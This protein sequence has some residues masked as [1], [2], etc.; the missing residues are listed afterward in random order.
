VGLRVAVVICVASWLG[1]GWAAPRWVHPLAGPERSLPLSRTREFGA[2]RPFRR[3]PECRRGH[4]GVDLGSRRGDSVFAVYDGIVERIERD[5]DRDPRSGRYVRL[6]HEGGTLV[7]RYIH[8]D[9]IRADLREG[10]RVA[11]GEII[12]TLG[13]TGVFSSGP[14]LHFSISARPGGR[15]ARERYLDPEPFL[16]LW[17]LKSPSK[18]PAKTRLPDAVLASVAHPEKVLASLFATPP[19]AA[20][21]VATPAPAPRWVPEHWVWSQRGWLWVPAGWRTPRPAGA[22]PPAYV[23]FWVPGHWS[24]SGRAWIW[25]PGGWRI[26]TPGPVV[27]QDRSG[28]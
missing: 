25:I 16:R 24:W 26:H 28:S 7:T 15:G 6:G 18:A 10:D 3:P 2:S 8:L 13:S 17:S 20:P 21:P 14:H 11:G 1:G 5:A 4:C 19:E 9:S 27:A 23:A 22:P 12:G